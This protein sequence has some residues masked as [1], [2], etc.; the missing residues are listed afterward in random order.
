MAKKQKAK[1]EFD[2]TA[3]R[4]EKEFKKIPK[5]D[6]KVDS[7]PLYVFGSWKGTKETKVASKISYKPRYVSWLLEREQRRFQR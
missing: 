1:V 3:K 2:K 5:I 4:T 7:K 6:S